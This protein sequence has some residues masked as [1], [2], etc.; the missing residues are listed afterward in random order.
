M[1]NQKKKRLLSIED[2]VKF[3]EEQKLYSFNSKE[4]GYKLSVQVPANFE[5]DENIDDDHRGMLKLKFRIFH[6]GLNRNGSYVS[7]DAAKNAMPTIKNRPILAYIHQLDD[8]SWDFESHNME[9]IAHEDGTYEIEY[10]EKQIGSFDESEPFFEYDEEL[11][12]TYVCGYGYV[13]E[14]YTKAAD[15][16]REK[17]GTKNSCELS[18]EEFAYNAKEKYLDLK[19]FYVA[20][21]TLLG[22]KDDGTE[23]G[24]G[25]LGSRADIA[26]F[27]EQNNSQ[28]SNC[29]DELLQ[30]IKKLN[31]NLSLYNKEKSKEGG[32]EPVKFEEL[33]EKYGK[34][35]EDIEFEYENMTDEELEAKFEEVFGEDNADGEGSDPEPTSVGE[36]GEGEANN[37]PETFENMVRTYEISHSDV[38]Y[39]LYQLLASY[40]EADNEYYWITDVYDTYFVYENWLGDRIFGQ[41]YTKE[42]DEVAFSEERYNLHKE[43]L[44]DAEFA[45]LTAMRSNYAEIKSQLEKYQTEEQNALKDALFVSEEYSSISDKE[46]FEALKVNHEEFSLEELRTKLDGII[47][48]YAK[49]NSLKFSVEEPENKK[50]VNQTKLPINTKTN[51]KS[52]YGSIFNK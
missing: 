11:D 1:G 12:K 15:I 52:R 36:N 7:E 19:Q 26:D 45:E 10:L 6:T 23:I 32:H 34:T 35:A 9:Y 42:N 44:T 38:R 14:E 17:N 22:A 24:E 46:E 8:G 40:E 13:S 33:L 25:M 3:C 49:K 21:S 20:A 16:I 48:D 5:V 39:A 28:F 4:T 29:S 2:L 37:E 50:V 18:I 43:L 30:E 51:K 27:S 41:K 31:E 47:L